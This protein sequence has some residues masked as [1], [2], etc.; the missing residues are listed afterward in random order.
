M[1]LLP[2]TFTPPSICYQYL[3]INNHTHLHPIQSPISVC[4]T[5]GSSRTSPHPTPR[6][7]APERLR[8][9]ERAPNERGTDGRTEETFGGWMVGNNRENPP[10]RG[11][12]RLYGL[13]SKLSRGS[14]GAQYSA[15]S[16]R[17]RR[18][19]PCTALLGSFRAS[20]KHGFWGV[21]PRASSIFVGFIRVL[22]ELL[23]PVKQT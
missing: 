6:G 20:V 1:P 3:P 5:P 14:T 4:F 19:R 16:H 8:S 21:P 11:S 15:I 7:A 9:S 13:C 2:P 17:H 18:T 10:P 12:M 23:A 22:K